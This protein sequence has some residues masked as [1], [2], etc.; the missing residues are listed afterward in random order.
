VKEEVE[1]E[2]E[3][4]TL[5][6]AQLRAS[7]AAV[8]KRIGNLTQATATDLSTINDLIDLDVDA[9]GDEV[10]VDEVVEAVP[11]AEPA[12]PAASTGPPSR[13]SSGDAD[14]RLE[15]RLAELRKQ[16]ERS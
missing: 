15:A 11:P 10:D 7:L 4:S 6:L 9:L 12:E 3:E 1:Q 14:R 8:K 13:R 5:R 2:V 16:L